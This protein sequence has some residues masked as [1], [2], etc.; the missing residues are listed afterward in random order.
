MNHQF[1]TDS[2]KRV[3]LALGHLLE[4]P[5]ILEFNSQRTLKYLPTI[6]QALRLLSER[7]REEK[8]TF[9]GFALAIGPEERKHL[10]V[11]ARMVV[12]MV[13]EGNIIHIPYQ[14]IAH[15]GEAK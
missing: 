3:S 11:G 4:S 9:D 13:A 7:D 10:L 1:Y 5:K 6:T 14:S 12:T 8:E 15:I 2:R